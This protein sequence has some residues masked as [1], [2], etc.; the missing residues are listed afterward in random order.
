MDAEKIVSRLQIKYP[1]KTI[2]Q[3]PFK[4]PKEIICE[5]EPTTD[6][7]EYSV[8]VAVIEDSEP[9]VH[10]LSTEKY[11]VV[12]G[13]VNLFVDG[14]PRAMK[15]GVEYTIKPGKV[16]WAVANSATVEVTSNPGWTLSDHI[17][18]K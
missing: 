13:E 4:N 12:E 2:L 11:K 6:H 3:L 9:H 8:A 7:P 14:E 17:L 18:I 10:R 5:A 1:G 16:H 15:E